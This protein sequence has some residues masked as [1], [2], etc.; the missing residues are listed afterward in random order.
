MPGPCVDERE[1]KDLV[2]N[3]I[4]TIGC[5]LILVSVGKEQLAVAAHKSEQCVAYIG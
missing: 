2:D 3:L 4:K 1:R 5:Y